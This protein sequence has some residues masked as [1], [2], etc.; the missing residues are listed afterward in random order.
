M[1]FSY[2]STH[3]SRLGRLSCLAHGAH[4][5]GPHTLDYNTTPVV[6]TIDRLQTVQCTTVQ[7]QLHMFERVLYCRVQLPHTT[8]AVLSVD[9][10]ATRQSPKR[11]RRD[12]RYCILHSRPDETELVVD[13]ELNQLICGRVD[14]KAKALETCAQLSMRD[15]GEERPQLLHRSVLAPRRLECGGEAVIIVAITMR[16]ER[17]RRRMSGWWRSS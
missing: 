6:G 11:E 10:T 3:S 4:G 14:V 1:S 5:Q 9:F 13:A 12:T 7:T 16:V 8:T 15:F 2:T 17:A